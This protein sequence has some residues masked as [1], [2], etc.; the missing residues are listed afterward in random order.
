[1]SDSITTEFTKRCDIL[2]EF[3]IAYRDEE[4]FHDFFRYNALGLSLAFMLSV[5]LVTPVLERDDLPTAEEYI[6]ETWGLFLAILEL[7]DEGFD[8]LADIMP[9]EPEEGE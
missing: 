2:G 1:M 8:T 3:W 9:T 6:N 5:N 7:E 4:S